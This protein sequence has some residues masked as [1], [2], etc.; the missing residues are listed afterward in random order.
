MI[1]QSRLL[2]NGIT[3]VILNNMKTA[4]SIPD[5]IFEAAESLASSLGLSRSEL[6]TRAV[7]EF[8][9][10]EKYK[11]VTAQLNKVYSKNQNT[12][13]K[14]LTA[15]QHESIGHEDWENNEAW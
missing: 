7:T 8:I 3:Q 13:S 9:E 12:L 14:D 6:F 10:T 5:P 1:E 2:D 11:N 4:I 15:M